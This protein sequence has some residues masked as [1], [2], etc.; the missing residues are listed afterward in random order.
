MSI[1]GTKGGASKTYSYTV[2]LQ[3]GDTAFT[4][5]LRAV[6][7]SNVSYTGSGATAF[8]TAIYG[9]ANATTSTNGWVYSVNGIRPNKS[10]GAY[11]LSNG[12]KI[13]WLYSTQGY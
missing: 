2:N 12:D 1:D 4:V 13:Q 5:L 9:V 3:S 6:G 7:K 11:P 8:V 10:A